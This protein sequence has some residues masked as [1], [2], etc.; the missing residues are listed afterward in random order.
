MQHLLLHPID[1]AVLNRLSHM[2]CLQVRVTRQIGDR[3]CHFEDASIKCY[4][5]FLSASRVNWQSR[6]ICANKPGPSVSPE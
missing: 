5:S 3:S 4:K 1:R 6:N 2:V